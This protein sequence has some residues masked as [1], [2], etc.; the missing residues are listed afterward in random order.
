MKVML[1]HFWPLL[2]VAPFC[3]S[4]C[5]S[6]EGHWHSKHV[7]SGK[8]L[9]LMIQFTYPTKQNIQN[10]TKPYKT[11]QNHTKPCK[12][13]PYTFK[14]WNQICIDWK[15]QHK[16]SAN[17]VETPDN[18]PTTFWTIAW[19]PSKKIFTYGITI[20]SIMYEAARRQQVLYVFRLARVFYLITCQT[21]TDLVMMPH[22]RIPILSEHMPYLDR[23]GYDA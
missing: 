19:C 12:T 16:T 2:K 21:W 4:G 13:R 1:T 22:G 11:I 6:K 23:L 7:L 17:F 3:L 14:I 15:S 5:M 8:V 18:T 9:M 20:M 10:H